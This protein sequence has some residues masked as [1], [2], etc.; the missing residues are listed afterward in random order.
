[1]KKEFRWPHTDEHCAIL[2][3]TG[4]GKTTLAA[5]VLS[6]MPFDKMPYVAIDMKGDDLLGSISHLKEIGLH[7]S[8]PSQPGL[9]VLRPLPSDSEGIEAWLYKLWR[10]EQTGLYVD[11]AYLLPDKVWMRNILA[12][13]RSKRI[14]TIC[15]SQRPVDVQRSIF[16]EA[17]H[18]AVFRLNDDDDKK[19]V[20]QFS[21]KGMLDT[22]LPEHHCTWYSP[23]WHSYDDPTPWF[24]LKPVPKP[25]EIAE[26]INERLKP[27]FKII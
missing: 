6:V 3:C 20:R 1:M 23:K 9:Y 4:S 12:Q 8:I 15:A 13:G 26:R 27:V 7:E 5:H 21:P 25:E 14:P 17:S 2:G 24:V 10:K 19:R 22:R 11:E 18:L 16:S